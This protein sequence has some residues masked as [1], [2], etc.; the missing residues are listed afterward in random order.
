[1]LAAVSWHVFVL[2]DEVR[3]V[4]GTSQSH[5]S[6]DSSL[7]F[8]NL[9]STDTTATQEQNLRARVDPTSRQ[10][11]ATQAIQIGLEVK[12][13]HAPLSQILYEHSITRS[14]SSRRFA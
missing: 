3:E 5:C 11:E 4:S 12:A 7:A 8:H 13:H 2:I 10:S 6:Q 9:R 1:M 14:V